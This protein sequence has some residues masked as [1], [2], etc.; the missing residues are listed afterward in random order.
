MTP[1]PKRST[2]ADSESCSPSNP[3][4]SRSAIAAASRSPWR[5]ESPVTIG[6]LA[7]PPSGRRTFSRMRTLVFPIVSA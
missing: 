6:T 3:A 4:E 7:H 2:N 1:P 5:I